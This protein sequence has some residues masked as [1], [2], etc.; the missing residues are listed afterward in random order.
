MELQEDKFARWIRTHRAFW[1]LILFVIGISMGF[2]I[3]AHKEYGLIYGSFFVIT[4]LVAGGSGS[5]YG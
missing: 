2:L 5:S 3:P 1:C 4:E